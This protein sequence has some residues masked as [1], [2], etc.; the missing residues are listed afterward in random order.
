M[1]EL[2]VSV[3]TVDD[4]AAVLLHSWAIWSWQLADVSEVAET[5]LFTLHA[6]RL[7]A[8]MPPLVGYWLG[9]AVYMKWPKFVVCVP[10]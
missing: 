9:K 10:S 6:S 5:A 1:Q 2:I 4:A 3:A 8:L 7:M